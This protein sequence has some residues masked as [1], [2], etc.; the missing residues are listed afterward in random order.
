MVREVRLA[1]EVRMAG[2][3]ERSEV[4]SR[5]KAGWQQPNINQRLIISYLLTIEHIGHTTF[6]GRDV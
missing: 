6:T 4:G 5:S 1:A 2:S 3:S